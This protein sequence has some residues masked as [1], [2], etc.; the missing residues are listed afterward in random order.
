MG[1]SQFII[2]ATE[3]YFNKNIDEKNA[4]LEYKEIYGNLFINEFIK[5]LFALETERTFCLDKFLFGH[6]EDLKHYN[7]RAKLLECYSLS[8]NKDITSEKEI[9]D[10][11]DEFSEEDD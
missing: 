6:M 9:A 7:I 4:I 3:D 11:T 5:K 10:L 8:L 2:N 1:V